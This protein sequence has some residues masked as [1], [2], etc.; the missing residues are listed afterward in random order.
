MEEKNKRGRPKKSAARERITF[1][2]RPD[3]IKWLNEKIKNKS[4]F[5]ENLLDT[6][7]EKEKFFKK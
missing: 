5:L 7:I 6:E 1:R 3:L 4:S 2:I